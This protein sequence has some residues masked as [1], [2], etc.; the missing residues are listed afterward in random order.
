MSKPFSKLFKSLES[1]KK[2][3]S[4]RNLL[5]KKEFEKIKQEMIEEFNAHPITQEIELGVTAPNLSNTLS[6]VTNLFS[7]IGF[8]AVSRPIDPIRQLLEKSTFRISSGGRSLATATFEI[9]TAKMIF[10]A[11][12]MPWA[13]GRSWAKGIERGISGLGFYLKKKSVS[14]SG[15]GIQSKRRVRGGLKFQNTQYISALINKYEKKFRD[16]NRKQL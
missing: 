9:P 5:I 4:K 10:L 7:F 16:L 13:N 11:T 3:V 2:Y 15:F 8:D 12:P 6:G 14:R 1:D